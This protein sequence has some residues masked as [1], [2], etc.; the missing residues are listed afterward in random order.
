MDRLGNEMLES[1]ATERDL[2]VLLNDKFNMSQQSQ[3]A[4]NT[5][6]ETAPDRNVHVA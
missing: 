1:S 5:L 3:N 4:G 6:P 2:G